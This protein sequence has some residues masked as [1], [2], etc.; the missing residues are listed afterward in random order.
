MDAINQ[1]S[2]ALQGALTSKFQVRCTFDDE[3]ESAIDGL[4]YLDHFDYLIHQVSECGHAT[5][6]STDLMAILVPVLLVAKDVI[7]PFIED[8]ECPTTLKTMHQTLMTILAS[9]EDAY[10]SN[11]MN[12]Y[13]RNQRFDYFFKPLDRPIQIANRSVNASLFFA[14][15]MT[16]I[17]SLETQ[18]TKVEICRNNAVEDLE[19]D[20]IIVENEQIKLA[21]PISETENAIESL[22][23]LSPIEIQAGVVLIK[24]NDH[25]NNLLV[26]SEE[27]KKFRVQN[28]I[29]HHPMTRK[30]LNE[31]SFQILIP[32][33]NSQ[34]VFNSVEIP[35]RLIH[36]LDELMMTHQQTFKDSMFKMIS[37]SIKPYPNIP[38]DSNNG[39][40]LAMEIFPTNAIP[41]HSNIDES[42][43]NVIPI[44]TPLP[45]LAEVILVEPIPDVIPS[46]PAW[47]ELNRDEF[48]APSAPPLRMVDNNQEQPLHLKWMYQSND[49]LRY[50]FSNQKP[51]QNLSNETIAQSIISAIDS[52]GQHLPIVSQ[53]SLAIDRFYTHWRNEMRFFKQPEI[54]TRLSQLHLDLNSDDLIRI[55]LARFKELL[56]VK[57]AFLAYWERPINSI[58]LDD[59]A[60]VIRELNKEINQSN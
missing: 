12:Q 52:A 39:L 1:D 8:N 33:F 24:D 23:T 7:D 29:Q 45:E 35:Y 2:V 50:Q 13:L 25:N 41:H 22:F 60:Q 46:A 15:I 44:A 21:N 5:N 14:D 55:S 11:Q 53:E 32:V 37:D 18:R 59:L 6:P 30:P 58:D 36:Q 54:R 19:F 10:K 3:Y 47:E 26:T 34:Q 9:S 57:Q 20:Q 28:Q 27:F 40:E 4:E 49:P 56:K 51:H 38:T 42:E 16:M 31:C 17:G 43:N 48:P